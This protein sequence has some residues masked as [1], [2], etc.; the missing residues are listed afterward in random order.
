MAKHTVY[1]VIRADRDIRVTKR[2]PSLRRDEIA[3]AL[4]LHFPD[5]WGRI[6]DRIDLSVPDFT[7]ALDVEPGHLEAGDGDDG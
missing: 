1:L 3:V 5:D 2:V 6:H 7:P 4:N